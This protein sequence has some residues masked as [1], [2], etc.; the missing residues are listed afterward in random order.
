M[1][2]ID[3]IDIHATAGRGG[4]GVVLLLVDAHY[5]VEAIDPGVALPEEGFVQ[6][7]RVGDHHHRAGPRR[8]PD[9]CLQVINQH[10]RA[11]DRCDHCRLFHVSRGSTAEFASPFAA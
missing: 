8:L 5:H 1:A 11:R 6:A 2:F 3:E 10:A 9:H 7:I 4:N